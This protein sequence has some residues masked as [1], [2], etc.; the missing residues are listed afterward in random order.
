MSG[1][2]ADTVFVALAGGAAYA[3]REICEEKIS[4]WRPNGK[5]DEAAFLKSVQ[6]GRVELSGGWFAFLSVA[7]FCVLG[8]AFP[9]NPAMNYLVGVIAPLQNQMLES[10]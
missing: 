9:T 4:A 6:Q 1:P 7:L 8:I 5:F 3:E 2:V 10:Y